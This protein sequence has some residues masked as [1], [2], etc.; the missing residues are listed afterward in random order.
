MN[1]KHVLILLPRR[2]LR[3]FEFKIPNSSEYDSLQNNGR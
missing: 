2:I 3:P 1:M